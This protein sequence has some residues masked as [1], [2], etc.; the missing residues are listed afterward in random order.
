MNP[1]T[2]P[3][4]QALIQQTKASNQK[5]QVLTAPALQ[6]QM[7][8]IPQAMNQ[9]IPHHQNQMNYQIPQQQQAYQE[10]VMQTTAQPTRKRTSSVSAVENR[11]VEVENNLKL[12]LDFLSSL[13]E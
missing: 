2:N 10:P 5:Q 6:H 12:V 3:K 11:L 13:D 4:Y 8:T 7:N 1:K 9:Q